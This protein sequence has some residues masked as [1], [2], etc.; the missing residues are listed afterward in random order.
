MPRQTPVLPGDARGYAQLI[1]DATLGLTDVVETM[2]HTIARAPGPLGAG[3]DAP[4]PGLTGFVYRSIRGITR[5]VG[6]GVDGALGLI[7]PA[8]A[9]L[10]PSPMR[11]A[12]VAAVNGVLGDHLAASGNPLAIAMAWRHG[13]TPLVMNREA[14]A[15]AIPAAGSRILVALHGLCMHSGQWR[16]KGHDHAAALA[17]EAGFTPIYLDYNSGR[18]ISTNGRELASQLETLVQNWPRTVEELVILGHSMGGL[19]AR[20]AVHYGVQAGHRW[21]ALLRR[22]FFLG[23]PHHGAPLERGGNGIDVVLGVSPYTVALA[24]LGKIRSA[25]ITDLRHGS[26]LDADWQHRDRFAPGAEDH[27]PVPLP[28]EVACY[29]VAAS[30]ARANSPLR[31][32]FVGDGLVPLP[33]ALGRHRRPNRR[34]DFPVTR[35]AVFYG[36]NHL[37]LLD[38]P[39]VYAQLQHWFATPA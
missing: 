30:L 28:A 9:S 33:S 15:R 23:T 37:D 6:S 20:S 18:H 38:H 39:A 25:G 31:D 24:R 2:H 26:L 21:P 11:E 1:I 29:A 8:G 17:A 12:V 7:A 3:T 4:A 14:L 35:Q 36:L 22:L 13:G 5:L 32:R 27:A 19:L 10:A 34:L 16:R